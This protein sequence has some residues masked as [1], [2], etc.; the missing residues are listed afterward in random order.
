MVLVNKLQMNV[1]PKYGGSR[2]KRKNSSS[3]RRKARERQSKRDTEEADKK[4]FKQAGD[5]LKR[6]INK[7]KR[8]RAKRLIKRNLQKWRDRDEEEENAAEQHRK[9]AHQVANQWSWEKPQKE[10]SIQEQWNIELDELIYCKSV[11]QC[12]KANNDINNFL[13][14]NRE[15]LTDVIKKEIIRIAKFVRIDREYLWTTAVAESFGSIL[16]TF[17]KGGSKQ[18]I[19]N[20]ITNPKTGRQ[21]SI[22]GKLGKQI[23]NGYLSKSKF[24]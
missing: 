21:V 18:Y 22:Y 3:S 2:G 12:L 14:K 6:T 17:Q 24:Y 10:L 7:E 23:L 13:R 4:R 9:F 19:Y 16:R 5:I 15:L 8:N 1:S 11:E 20:K